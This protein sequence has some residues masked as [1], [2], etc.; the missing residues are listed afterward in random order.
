MDIAPDATGTDARDDDPR[1]AYI[2][3][4]PCRARPPQHWHRHRHRHRHRAPPRRLLSRARTHARRPGRGPQHSWRSPRP[5]CSSS[6]ATASP[7]GGWRSAARGRRRSSA[8]SPTPSTSAIPSAA[9]GRSSTWT[10]PSSSPCGGRGRPR[11][12]RR[13][14]ATST[15]AL[16]PAAGPV[17][18]TLRPRCCSARAG[19]SATAASSP[20]TPASSRNAAPTRPARRCSARPTARRRLRPRPRARAPAGGP[21]GGAARRRGRYCCSTS[22]SWCRYTGRWGPCVGSRRLGGG[23]AWRRPARRARP[24]PASSGATAMPTPPSATPSSTARSPA[25][26]H[27]SPQIQHPHCTDTDDRDRSLCFVLSSP[28]DTHHLCTNFSGTGR[29]HDLDVNSSETTCRS[30]PSRLRL[31]C[32]IIEFLACLCTSGTRE[33]PTWCSCSI[34]IPRLITL[35]VYLTAVWMTRV[36]FKSKL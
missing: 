25:Y 28:T 19:S 35:C 11:P 22:G 36:Q 3:A 24:R 8:S 15:S 26:V 33:R 13:R 29:I 16:F 1:G 5:R 17:A 30:V 14:R 2:C 6:S 18:V 31:S 10:P 34:S 4:C 23:P 20:A 21:P 27:R 32:S 12:R 9:P 7:A